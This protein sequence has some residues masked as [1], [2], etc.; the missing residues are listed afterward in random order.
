MQ[1]RG[2]IV[3][4]AVLTHRKAREEKVLFYVLSCLSLTLLLFHL[5]DLNVLPSWISRS[6]PPQGRSPIAPDFSL[7]LGA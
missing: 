1:D 5:H 2:P 4:G 7:F 3:V 6:S